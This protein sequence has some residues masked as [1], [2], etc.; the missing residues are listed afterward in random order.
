MIRFLQRVRIPTGLLQVF[1]HGRA[2]LPDRAGLGQRL[3]HPERGGDRNGRSPL[4]EGEPR[5]IHR[6]QPERALLIHGA[7]QQVLL[8]QVAGGVHLALDAETAQR[9]GRNLPVCGVQDGAPRGN[10]HQVGR[11][12]NGVQVA[13]LARKEAG[14]R[15]ETGLAAI[16]DG[17]AHLI[18]VI[19]Q[20]AH[21][22]A[23]ERSPV[24]HPLE[25]GE[26]ARLQVA[27]RR[28][29]LRAVGRQ[30]KLHHHRA[31]S[32]V[33][34]GQL[35]QPEVNG[36]R[37]LSTLRANNALPAKH[38]VS[39]EVVRA[40]VEGEEAVHVLG[41]P[42]A[43]FL[44]RGAQELPR[45]RVPLAQGQPAIR[46][47]LLPEIPHAVQR[48]LPANGVLVD[49][50]HQHGGAFLFI[51]RPNHR[52]LRAGERKQAAQRAGPDALERL[53]RIPTSLARLRLCRR[54]AAESGPQQAQRA[55]QRA[56]NSHMSHIKGSS[57]F[58]FSCRPAA[59]LL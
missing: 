24:A 55:E 5:R 7:D 3:V 48:D 56:K 41:L 33:E 18:V 43:E 31:A 30:E 29:A 21:V 54:F 13:R 34:G 36:Q 42:L 16:G 47:G 12:G 26:L 58:P 49:V 39:Q 52:H 17:I 20:K 22:L 23:P 46:E 15:K 2:E 14:V 25:Q 50:R 44:Q 57:A 9:T 51:V 4:L 6:E 8:G 10:A 19:G 27:D 38:P 1:S 40:A 45:I 37:H 11:A 53:H 32:G 59:L 28:A 35:Q